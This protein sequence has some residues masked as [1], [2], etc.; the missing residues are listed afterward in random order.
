VPNDSVLV[1]SQNPGAPYRIVYVA[2][3]GKLKV[4]SPV[5]S[6]YLVVPFI[7]APEFFRATVPLSPKTYNNVVAAI[8]FTVVGL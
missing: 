1:F 3:V 5:E 8:L 6:Q 4:I 2:G 7:T